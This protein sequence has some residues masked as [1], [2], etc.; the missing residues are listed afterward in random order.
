MTKDN[1]SSE[2]DLLVFGAYNQVA[3][4]LQ[5]SNRIQL[6]YKITTSTWLLATFFGV[7]YSMSSREANLPIDPLLVGAILAFASLLVIGRIWYLD[8]IVQEKIIASAVHSGLL[9]EK[10]HPWLPRAYESI[11]RV[12]HLLGYVTIKSIFYFAIA[13]ILI[14]TICAALTTHLYWLQIAYWPLIPFAAL[15]S[16]GVLYY[17]L[18]FVNKKLDPYHL[19]Q[20]KK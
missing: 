19:L 16:L 4:L 18:H 10:Q 12:H 6:Q 17:L 15:I 7:G 20:Q 14:L 2:E 13:T 3:V 5:H 1:H 9:L 8:L 11:V